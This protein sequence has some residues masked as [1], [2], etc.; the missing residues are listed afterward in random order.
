MGSITSAGIGSGLDIESIITALIEAEQVPKSLSLDKREVAVQS[1]LASLSNLSTALSEL[2][3]SI[4]QINSLSDFQQRNVDV[5]DEDFLT[6]SATSTATPSS[7]DVQVVSVASGTKTKNDFAAVTASDAHGGSGTLTFAAGS[8][9][10]TVTIE[11]TDTFN[12]IRRKINDA[13]DNFGVN[14]NIINYDGGITFDIESTVTGTGN[15]LTITASDASL[16]GFDNISATPADAFDGTMTDYGAGAADAQIIINSGNP[17]FSDTNTFVNAVQDTTINVLKATTSDVS[18]D[19]SLDKQAVKDS[20]TGFVETL[21]SF[22]EIVQGLTSVTDDGV[23]LLTGDATVRQLESQLRRTLSE[24]SETDSGSVNALADLGISTTQDGKFELDS[25]VLD[26]IVNSE[27]DNVGE[28]FAADDLGL[29]TRLEDLIG[30]YIGSNGVLDSREE[31]LQGQLDRIADERAAL[32]LRIEALETRLRAKFG[33]MDVLV[34]QF[35][36]TGS[37][38]TQQLENLPGFSSGSSKN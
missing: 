11:A 34:S 13:S 37:Y 36:S 14:V 1:T 9:S 26:A 12:E 4:R 23:G 32:T 16:A 17:I 10:F 29:A 24:L 8:D 35:N 28:F 5:S 30:N 3:S 19:V 33:A 15:D 22:V 38:L 27:F 7:F 2:D 6:V 18:V 20:I 31:S 25:T 21:N